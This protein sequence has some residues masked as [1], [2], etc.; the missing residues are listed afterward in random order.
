MSLPILGFPGGAVVKNPPAM[1]KKKT[2]AQSLSQEDLLE[3]GMATHSSILPRKP[4]GQRSL[5]G[6]SPWGNSQTQLKSLRSSSRLYFT[7]PLLT[8]VYFPFSFTQILLAQYCISLWYI[9]IHIDIYWF[10]FYTSW[11]DCHNK[12]SEYPSFFI[13]KNF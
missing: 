8:F 13:D 11:H 9:D 2:W 1:Q 3:E 12:F 5:V 10:V 4:H 7:S 6:C